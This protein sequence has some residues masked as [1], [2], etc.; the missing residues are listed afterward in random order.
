MG[1]DQSTLARR[2]RQGIGQERQR[3]AAFDVE[4]ER[5]CGLERPFE[6]VESILVVR[7]DERLQPEAGMRIGKIDRIAFK[8]S[9]KPD[10]R[11][12]LERWHMRPDELGL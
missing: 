3:I 1:D 4:G 6:T 9:A 5:A 11:R 12:R 7:P 8:T 2:F 10:V